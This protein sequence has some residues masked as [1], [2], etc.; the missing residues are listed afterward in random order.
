MRN[1]LLSVERKTATADELTDSQDTW[2]VL[3]QVLGTITPLSGKELIEGN[4]VASHITHK[5]E[6]RWGSTLALLTSRDRIK[7]EDRAFNLVSV[8][9]VGERNRKFE[10]MATEVR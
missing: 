2:E 6:F 3:A 4:A 10:C 7:L 8:V 1:Y 9:N 5:I